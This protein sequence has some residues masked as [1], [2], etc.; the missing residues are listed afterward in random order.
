MG[1][2]GLGGRGLGGFGCI[3]LNGFGCGGLGF[4][5]FRF[6]GF[7]LGSFSHGGFGGF[8]LDAVVVLGLAI[9]CGSKR[10]T[11]WRAIK[12]TAANILFFCRARA[13]AARWGF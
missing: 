9:R 5:G 3:G 7:G 1:G 4:I 2:L 13:R 6:N 8:G 11:R 12:K 10:Q